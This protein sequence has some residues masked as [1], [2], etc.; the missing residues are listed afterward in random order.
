MSNQQENVT[1]VREALQSRVSV[2]RRRRPARRDVAL[3]SDWL[4]SLGSTGAPEPIEAAASAP[5]APA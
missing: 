4:R 1:A 2:D 5:E 3:V